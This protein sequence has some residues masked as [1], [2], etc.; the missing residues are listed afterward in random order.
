MRIAGTDTVMR[1]EL[2]SKVVNLAQVSFAKIRRAIRKSPWKPQGR[3][4]L[5]TQEVCFRFL[6]GSAGLV[7]VSSCFSTATYDELRR[8]DML[9]LLNCRKG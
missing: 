5:P 8:V 1:F 4:A 7:P 9:R 6:H 2:K 3:F